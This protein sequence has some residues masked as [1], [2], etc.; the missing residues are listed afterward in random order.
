MSLLGILSGIA[1]LLT[2]T[3]FFSRQSMLGFPCAIFWAITGA[4]AFTLSTI[5]WGDIEF[6]VFIGS[7]LGMTPFTAYAA[8]GLRE[9][10][11]SLAEEEMDARGYG[12]EDDLFTDEQEEESNLE[13]TERQKTSKRTQALR[14]RA[15]V[16][17][18]R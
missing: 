17:R 6:F 3:M 2:I 14:Q 15:I 7:I 13:N 11:D 12:E 9:K 8:F 18:T 10:R 4:R 5:P 16:R 1:V